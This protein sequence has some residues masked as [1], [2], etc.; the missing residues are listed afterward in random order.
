MKENA[1]RANTTTHI[2]KKLFD[3]R[4]QFL[5]SHLQKQTIFQHLLSDTL[6]FL[7]ATLSQTN[8]AKTYQ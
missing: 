7:G 4:D 1:L 5:Q 8:L 2:S 6:G 3:F